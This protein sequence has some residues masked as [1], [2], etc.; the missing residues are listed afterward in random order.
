METQY[1]LFDVTVEDFDTLMIEFI[2]IDKG[3]YEYLKVLGEIASGAN[4]TS[5]APG[6]PESNLVGN[7]LGFFGAYA[8]TNA[9]I[10]IEP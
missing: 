4:A 1:P 3:T 5:A 10:V 8:I 2:E 6:N 9:S 7:A